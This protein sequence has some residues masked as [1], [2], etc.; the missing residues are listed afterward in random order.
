M[1]YNYTK[2]K[3]DVEGLSFLPTLIDYSM[4]ADGA[5]YA[6][7]FYGNP[8][9]E[10][11]DA[12]LEVLKTITSQFIN[13]PINIMEIG[14]NR[15]GG[16]SFTHVLL[17]KHQNS[18]YLGI[19]INDKS[20]LNNSSLNIYTLKTDSI[21]QE[22]IRKTINDLG[23]NNLTILFIDGWHSVNMCLNDW[24][25]S[26]LVVPGGYILFHDVHMHPGPNVFM[27]AIDQTKYS[28]SVPL[29]DMPGNYGIGV[30]KKL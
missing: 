25:Y 16:R 30:I 8:T 20:E 2:E 6:D 26:D 23:M 17:N 1:I 27:D 29:K 18:K 4:D 10:V 21:N 9:N 28:V 22:L 3:T 14:V 5:P 12:E 13:V 15:N 19:D 11:S 7:K 24:K